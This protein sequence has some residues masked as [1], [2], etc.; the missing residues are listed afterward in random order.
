MPNDFW[1]K[2]AN[3]ADVYGADGSTVIGRL[4]PD[5]PYRA[6][7][8]NDHWLAIPSPNDGRGFVSI[9]NLEYDEIAPPGD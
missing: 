8:A 5:T 1:F 7:D 6:T 9:H 2:V 3:A 4:E